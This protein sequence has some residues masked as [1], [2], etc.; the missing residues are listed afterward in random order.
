[1]NEK[2]DK[3][4]LKKNRENVEWILTEKQEKFLWDQ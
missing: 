3:N 1:M 4:W 2:R